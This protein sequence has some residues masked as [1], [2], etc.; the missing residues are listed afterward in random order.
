MSDEEELEA[1]RY[2]KLLELQQRIAEEQR[3]AQIQQ[4]IEAQKQAVL[5]KILS[6][7]ARQRLTNLKMVKPEF[8]SQIEIQLIQLVQAGK[9]N[10]P[11][12]DED[13]KQILMHLQSGRR[14]IKIKR[15]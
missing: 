4:Q 14:E 6:P 9:I 13:L 8:V 11:I 2:R 3:R 7:D 15:R 1:I 12:T 5:R 10:V